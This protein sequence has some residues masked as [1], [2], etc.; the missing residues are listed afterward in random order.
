VIEL[1]P[2]RRED[3][4]VLSGGETP[5]DDFGPRSP[6]DTPGPCDLSDSGVLTVVTDLDEVVGEVEWH[7]QKWRWGPNDGSSCPM[8]GIW[9]RPEHRGRGYGSAAQSSLVAL[10]FAHTTANRIEAHTDVEN[11]AEQRALEK[12]GLRRE[13]VTRGAQWRGGAYHDGVLY[14][15]LRGDVG[16]PPAEKDDLPG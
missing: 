9:I 2:Q 10:I 15:V 12:A 6:R 5:F 14:A 3:L 8:F 16:P 1:R 4:P 11:L 13:G 7:W